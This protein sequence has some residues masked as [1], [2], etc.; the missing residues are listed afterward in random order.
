MQ[1]AGVNNMQSPKTKAFLWGIASI[2]L[3]EGL[4]LLVVYLLSHDKSKPLFT[5]LQSYVGYSGPIAIAYG[6]LAAAMIDVFLDEWSLWRSKRLCI[7]LCVAIG[8]LW[9]AFEAQFERQGPPT[10][11]TMWAASV[12]AAG[13]FVAAAHAKHESWVRIACNDEANTSLRNFS[14]Y[15]RTTRD[16]HDDIT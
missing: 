15:V 14:E 8:I 1:N 7:D 16:E 11:G 5:C 4:P 9:L 6:I 13:A 10:A 12:I 2:G 3:G